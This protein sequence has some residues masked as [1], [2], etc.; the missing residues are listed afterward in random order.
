MVV[1]GPGPVPLY[2]SRYMAPGARGGPRVVGLG[3]GLPASSHTGRELQQQSSSADVSDQ[4]APPRRPS[5]PVKHSQTPLPAPWT[6]L[7]AQQQ[8]EGAPPPSPVTAEWLRVGSD[9]GFQG[10]PGCSNA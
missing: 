6:A 8:P 5:R 2:S 7:P 1:E 10:S 4:G 3:S 9:R